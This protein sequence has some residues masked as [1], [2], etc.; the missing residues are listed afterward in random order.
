[1]KTRTTRVTPKNGAVEISLSVE[2]ARKKFEVQASYV[3]GLDCNI[4]YISTQGDAS[5]DAS[6]V[7]RDSP[8]HRD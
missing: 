2:H 1:M 8:M 3:R 4:A 7:S 6:S 5:A